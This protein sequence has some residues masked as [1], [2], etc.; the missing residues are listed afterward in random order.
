MKVEKAVIEQIKCSIKTIIGQTKLCLIESLI[1]ENGAKRSCWN[2]I[3]M[4]CLMEIQCC[5]LERFLWK[6]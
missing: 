2:E 6:L 4:D 3:K 5:S 1:H